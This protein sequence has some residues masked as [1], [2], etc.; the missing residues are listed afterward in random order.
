[1]KDPCP[2]CR[3]GGYEIKRVKREVIVPA[4]VDDQMRIR[5]SGEG[6]PSPDGGP[7]GDCY[8]VVHLA[9]H[10]LFQREGQELIVRV[11]IA[12]SQAALGATIEVPTLEG[13]EPL[14]VPAGTQ[15]GEVFKLR[16]RGM[17]D[18][19][20]RGRGDLLV[21]V[22]IEVPKHLSAR[23]ETLLRDLAAEEQAHVSPHRK[24]FFDKLKKYFVPAEEDES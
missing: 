16:G 23:Q 24:K 21:E 15:S 3:G 12:Y 9:P 13:R 14:D 5:L 6:D 8:C 20:R 10:P 11:P 7:A 2:K 17:P 18:P 19:R 1:M 22:N 4:G